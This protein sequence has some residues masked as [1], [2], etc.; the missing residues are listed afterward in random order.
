MNIELVLL[1]DSNCV[2]FP[3]LVLSQS[4]EST[5]SANDN[6]WNENESDIGKTESYKWHNRSDIVGKTESYVLHH[7]SDLVQ[8]QNIFEENV[9]V[10]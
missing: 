10:P 4:I 5:W 8:P 6:Q 7:W 1:F 9:P 3:E 2:Y